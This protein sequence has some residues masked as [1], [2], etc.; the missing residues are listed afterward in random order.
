ML[1]LFLLKE[2]QQIKTEEIS[3]SFPH[4]KTSLKYHQENMQVGANYFILIPAV[5]E[6]TAKRLSNIAWYEGGETGFS[7]KDIRR[8]SFLDSLLNKGI[9]PNNPKSSRFNAPILKEN[10]FYYNDVST[11]EIIERLFLKDGDA[12]NMRYSA[13]TKLMLAVLIERGFEIT[14]PHWSATPYIDLENV[15][16]EYK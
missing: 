12:R 1:N 3:Y 13:D 4:S 5:E 16:C 11:C 8:L 14:V 2:C 15:N 7:K 6:K 9:N 10:F